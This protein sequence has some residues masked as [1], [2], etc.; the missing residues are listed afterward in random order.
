MTV[1]YLIRH[2]E[3]LWNREKRLQG[4]I[5]IGLNENGYW[6]AQRVGEY[7]S[8][9]PLAAVIS[10][11]LSR[12]SETA[13]AVAKHHGLKLQLEPHIRERH[14]GLMQGLSHQ[15][16]MDLH[17]RNHAAWKNREPDFRPETGETLR[18]FYARVCEAFKHWAS[19]YEG[20]EIAM[21]A[22]GGVLD[23]AYRLASN[24]PLDAPRNFE[25]LNA[26]LNTMGYNQGVFQLIEWGNVS[27][28]KDDSD[29]SRRSLDELDGSPKWA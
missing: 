24:M 22:H 14:Y 28:L 18:E 16:V 11:D 13:L 15:E 12:A 6:Q 26:S 21:V 3:T 5:D 17:P 4:H 7:L 2:G 20:Q 27:F 19:Q 10:S 8:T 29:Q 9:K 25:I 1:I 23:C